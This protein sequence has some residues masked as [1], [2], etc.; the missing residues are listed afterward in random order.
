MPPVVRRVE[1]K[2]KDV[3]AMN[4]PS[5]MLL[6]SLFVGCYLAMLPTSPVA[7]QNGPAKT[8]AAP[9]TLRLTLDEVK[10]RVLA[11]NK[12]LQLAALNVQSKGY[13]TRAAQALYF[14]QVIGNVV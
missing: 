14:P 3:L 2:H 6:L 12:L 1:R 10:Q 13:A 4:N 8:A 5:R 7:A 11:D 9:T